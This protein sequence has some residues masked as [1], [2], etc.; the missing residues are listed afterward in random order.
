MP[1][2]RRNINKQINFKSVK[3]FLRELKK[4]IKYSGTVSCG[5]VVRGTVHEEIVYKDKIFKDNY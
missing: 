5:R 3:H 4:I 2:G 1:F